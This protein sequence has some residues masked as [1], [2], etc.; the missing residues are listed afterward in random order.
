MR[1]TGRRK[2]KHEF[3]TRRVFKHFDPRAVKAGDG[4]DQAQ[5]ET[6][7][8]RIAALLESVKALENMLILIGGNPPPVIGDRNCRPA[9]HGFLR[10]HHAPP[11]P[12]VLDCTVDEI[13]DCVKDQ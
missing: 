13:G 9:L 8:W 7:S 12:T 4:S 5:S 10:P 6:V 11:S 2:P 1:L 3:E